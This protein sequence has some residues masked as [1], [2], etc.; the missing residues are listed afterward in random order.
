MNCA[1]VLVSAV[2]LLGVTVTPAGRLKVDVL[3]STLPKKLPEGTMDT[4]STWLPPG[5][6]T[7]GLLGLAPELSDKLNWPRIRK[8][9]VKLT[10]VAPLTPVTVNCVSPAAAPTEALIWKFCEVPAGTRNPLLGTVTPAGRLPAVKFT[11]PVKPEVWWTRTLKDAELPMSTIT[12]FVLVLPDTES[13]KVPDPILMNTVAL[14]LKPPPEAEMIMRPINGCAPA[15]MLTGKVAAP[16]GLTTKLEVGVLM[17]ATVNEALTVTLPAKAPIALTFTTTLLE[18]PALITRGVVEDVAVDGTTA[19]ENAPEPA[20]IVAV[21]E[22]TKFP[23]INALMPMLSV[24]PAAT[25]AARL[26]VTVLNPPIVT[27]VETGEM[28]TPVGKL[29]LMSTSPANVGLAMAAICKLAELPGAIAIGVLLLAA[30]V[31]ESVT[32]GV[33]KKA[34]GMDCTS[35]PEVAVSVP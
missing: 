4:E 6:M 8:K 33:M 27:R 25:E 12:G 24:V 21:V 10:V 13:E 5:A 20:I 32:C 3:T 29:K 2:A 17:V 31:S 30:G 1:G 7:M 23:L 28:V 18:A 11:V 9:T 35:A 15:A 14:V 16:P 26:T 34:M 19:M 22:A